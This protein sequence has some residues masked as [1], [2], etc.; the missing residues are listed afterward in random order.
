MQALPELPSAFITL[1]DALVPQTMRADVD[2]SYCQR[3]TVSLRLNPLMAPVHETLDTLADFPLRPWAGHD[4]VFVVE[5]EWREQLTHHATA[6]DGRIYI[7]GLSSMAAVWALQAQPGEEILDLAAA[8][9]GKTSYIAACMQNTG[10][11][12]A[13]EPVKARFFRLKANLQRLGVRNSHTYM[14]DGAIVG[15]LTPERFDRVLLDA[16]CSS[17]AQ[18]TRLD[19]D[20]WSHWSVRKVKECA[21]LQTKLLRSAVQALKPGGVMV[22]ST[23]SLSPEE[24]ECVLQSVLQAHP[25]MQPQPLPALAPLPTL[26]GLTE[27][28]GTAL[29]ARLQHAVRILPSAHSD[30]FFICKLHKAA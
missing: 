15:R 6:G 3:K 25:E 18:F 5:P 29:D 19:P 13:V 10:R 16:P 24:N 27:W 30:A 1:L 7:Q 11:L 20:S 17:E 23:C 22:Y 26:P 21:R 14:K 2:A 4:E 12:A 28:N 8:P 9:G